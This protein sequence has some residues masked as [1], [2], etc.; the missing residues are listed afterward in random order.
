MAEN[1]WLNKDF[2]KVLGVS[3][4]ATA[5]EIKKAY[6]KLARKYHPDVN[7]TKDAEEK[8]KEVNE[9]Y[10]V[11]SDS[12]KKARYDQFGFA[13]VDPNFGAGGGG[14]GGGAGFDFGD[15]GDIFGSFFGGGGGFGGFGGG[16]SDPNAP[17]R[18]DDVQARVTISF[19]EAAK[20]CKR[21]I[22]IHRIE[23]CPDC[24]GSGAQKGSTTKTCPDCGGR[25]QVNV[26]QRTPFGV[27]STT[28]TCPKCGGRG[29]IVEKPCQKCRGG[30]RV[31][32]RRELEVNI[33]AGIDDRQVISVRGEGSMGSNGGPSGDLHV[34]VFVRPHPFFEREGYNIW[35][36][37]KVNFVQAALGDSIMVPTIDGKV[38]FDLPAGTQPGTVVSLKGKGIQYLNSRG[39]GDQYIRI[40]VEVP[41][42]LTAPQR[43][44]LKNFKD[45][46]GYSDVTP[47]EKRGF[48]G[49]KKK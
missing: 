7:K 35:Y 19:E 6:R 2:Y 3:K 20:G 30:G 22:E 38:K 29:K 24:G 44:A 15:L 18:G 8:F 11:L 14:Y 16:R 32:K 45:T 37:C 48:F 42:D 34:S 46:M 43:E 13:G 28:K 36:D 41:K 9:A 27:I 10:E 23:T 40:I 21:K 49:K 4:D 26:Q 33:P 39:R 17:R 12:E 1:E 31:S 5:D 47:D 25:G